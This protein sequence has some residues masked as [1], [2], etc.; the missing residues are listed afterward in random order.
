MFEL[1]PLAI[2]FAGS[3]HCLGMCGPLVLAYSLH[4]A[5]RSETMAE[6]GSASFSWRHGIFHHVAFHAG[7]LLS[8]GLLGTLAGGFFQAAALSSLFGGFRGSLMMIGGILLVFLGLV[9]LKLVP[10]PSFLATLIAMPASFLN[11]LIPPL[12]RSQRVGSKMLL[13][14]AAGFLPCCLSWAMIVLAA[15]TRN[16]VEGCFTMLAFGLGTVP[17]LFLVGLSTSFIS[18]KVR[19]PGERVAAASVMVTGFILVL[20]GAGILA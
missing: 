15:T 18:L 13:G 8:Y 19:F 4:V 12:F 1:L 9:L 17:A 14:L 3:L 16:A 7:R 10:L 5:R 11:R 6:G 20:R 2:G